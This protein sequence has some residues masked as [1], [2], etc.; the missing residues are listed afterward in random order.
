MVPQ[1]SKTGKVEKSVKQE[2]IAVPVGVELL[3]KS[4]VSAKKIRENIGNHC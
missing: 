1:I 2:G 3:A 4:S